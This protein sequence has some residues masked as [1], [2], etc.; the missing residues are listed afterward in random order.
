MVIIYDILEFNVL[1]V[2]MSAVLNHQIIETIFDHGVTDAEML[3][4][5]DGYP[6]SRENYLYSLDQ[7]S[8][9]ADLYRLYSIRNDANKASFFLEQIKDSSFKNQFKMRPC[10]AA[11]S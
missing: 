4:L 7:D 8:A 3:A 5:T 1:E 6:E 10:C 9:Y 2:L 11:H